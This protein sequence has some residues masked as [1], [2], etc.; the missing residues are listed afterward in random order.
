MKTGKNISTTLFEAGAEAMN[1]NTAASW[2]IKILVAN[3]LRIVI[4]KSL[5]RRDIL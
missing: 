1:T 3:G 2:D 5:P 4:K